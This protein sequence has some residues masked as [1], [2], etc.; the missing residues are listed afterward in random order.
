MPSSSSGVSKNF[1]GLCIVDSIRVN[2]TITTGGWAGAVMRGRTAA[3]EGQL[4]NPEFPP[5][6]DRS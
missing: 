1:K 6:L 5:H 4:I 2:V 3:R